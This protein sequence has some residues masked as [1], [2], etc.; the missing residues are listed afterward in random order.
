MQ[1]LPRCAVIINQNSLYIID[2]RA[3]LP[4]QTIA[5]YKHEMEINELRDENHNEY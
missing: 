5:I 3:T 1:Y 2:N 4:V